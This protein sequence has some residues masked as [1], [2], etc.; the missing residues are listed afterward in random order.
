MTTE[1]TERG[2]TYCTYCTTL[3][4]LKHTFSFPPLTIPLKTQ[5]AR[6]REDSAA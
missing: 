2:C 6:S 5:I 4:S 1:R 3:N